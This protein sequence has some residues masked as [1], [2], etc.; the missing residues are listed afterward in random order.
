MKLKFAI[1]ITTFYTMNFRIILL[2]PLIVI[3]SGLALG[4]SYQEMSPL[5]YPKKPF[6]RSSS[7]GFDNL[8]MHKVTF[9][10][11]SN[12]LMVLLHIQKTGGTAF[13]KHLVIDIKYPFCTCEIGI[14]RQC[15]CPRPHAMNATTFAQK[16]WLVSRFSTGWVC[17]VHP[18]LTLLSYCL[19]GL[20]RLFYI[21]MLRHPL[22]RFVSEYRHIQRGAT[23]RSSIARCDWFNTSLCF[24]NQED[25]S[26]AT[27]EEFISCHSNMAI[28]RQTRM[29]ADLENVECSNEF[30][31]LISRERDSAMLESAKRNLDNMAFFG[32]CEH[33]TATQKMFERAFGVEFTVNFKQSDDNTTKTLIE[34]LPHPVRNKILEINHLDMELYRYSVEVFARRCNR[35]FK[36]C[37]IST[38]FMT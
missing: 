37:D 7:I 8:T 34:T 24:S 11:T 6:I 15:L 18:D 22:Y 31:S 27:L 10:F 13:E 36:D 30:D 12:D 28:N 3:T 33:Q 26:N 19:Q 29:L 14:K 38:N 25:W 21:T 5:A 9:N 35:L 20:E 1:M 4:T 17:G 2:F 23:W 32:L 16:T